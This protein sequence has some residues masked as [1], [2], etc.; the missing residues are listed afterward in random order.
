MALR[1]SDKEYRMAPWILIGLVAVGLF[2]CSLAGAADGRLAG[3][4]VDQ[5]EQ[6]VIG[7]TIVVCDVK[8]GVPVDRE[9]F[10]ACTAENWQ[11]MA[12]AGTDDRGAFSV[13]D[14]PRGAYR[15]LAQSWEGGKQPTREPLAVNGSVVRIHGMIE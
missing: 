11:K 3:K 13:Q 15:L 4:L 14:V 9:S 6:P 8:T 5:Q 1:A 12:V 10:Q 2:W 7:A